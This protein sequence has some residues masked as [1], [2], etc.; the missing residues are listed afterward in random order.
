MPILIW[1]FSLQL[2]QKQLDLVQA[3]RSWA[4]RV[5]IGF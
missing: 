1:G 5:L 3:N 4:A 2:A